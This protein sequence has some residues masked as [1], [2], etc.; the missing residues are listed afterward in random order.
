MKKNEGGFTLVEVLMALLIFSVLS[1]FLLLIFTN[2]AG[3]FQSESIKIEQGLNVNDALAKI[4]EKV[5]LAS[6]V[7]EQFQDGAATFISGNEILI[8]AESSIDSSGNLIQDT[9]DYHVF[10]KEGDKLWFKLFANTQSSRKNQNQLLTK[11]VANIK[12][13][14]FDANNLPVAPKDSDKV[15]VTLAL[16]QKNGLNL[17]TII[18]TSDATLRNN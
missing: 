17:S 8:L 18:A 12:F 10:T 9:F 4:R 11:N 2:S 14:Y 1:G 3:V 16:N 15:K 6:F 7:S 13:E 5:K